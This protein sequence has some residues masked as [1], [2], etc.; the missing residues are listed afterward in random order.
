[1]A[2]VIIGESKARAAEMASEPGLV[3][4]KVNDTGRWSGR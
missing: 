1:M 4:S 3:A 2:G